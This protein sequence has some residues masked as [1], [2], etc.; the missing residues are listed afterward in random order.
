MKFLPTLRFYGGWA[1]VFVVFALFILLD[2]NVS[3]TKRRAKVLE[4]Y[5]GENITADPEF[6]VPNDWHPEL[7]EKWF[8]GPE[9]GSAAPR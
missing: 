5:T 2:G 7:R 4:A 3:N 6:M 1:A 9:Q 8:V